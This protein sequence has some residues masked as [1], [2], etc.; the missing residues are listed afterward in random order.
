LH[1]TVEPVIKAIPDFMDNS[2]SSQ[3]NFKYYFRTLNQ[4]RNSRLTGQAIA[5]MNYET[6]GHLCML[7]K[8]YKSETF[9]Y[10][11]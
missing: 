3:K 9:N 11:I 4:N 5:D 1:H 8:A 7:Y 6:C 10:V 2:P